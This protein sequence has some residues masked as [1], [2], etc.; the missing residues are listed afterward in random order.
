MTT[1]AQLDSRKRLN[2]AP[3]APHD[4][5]IVTAEPNG[6]ITLE[7]ADVISKLERAVL[8]NPKIMAEVAA[9]QADPTDVIEE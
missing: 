1:I 8:D 2:L 4:L 7:P 3:Y 5:Y 9:Y 6:R